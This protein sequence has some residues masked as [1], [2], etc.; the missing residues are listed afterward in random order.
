MSD[1]ILTVRGAYKKEKIK[2]KNKSRRDSEYSFIDRQGILHCAFVRTTADRRASLLFRRHRVGTAFESNRVSWQKNRRKNKINT[3]RFL[4]CSRTLTTP[5]LR[6][7]RGII[8]IICI[9][10]LS[11][12]YLFYHL[13]V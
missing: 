7:F 4:Q 12:V 2:I 6:L 13:P 3:A 9:M 5:L 11:Y 1:K 8:I 10:R